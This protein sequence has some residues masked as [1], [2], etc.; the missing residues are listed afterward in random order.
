ME[1]Y[2]FLLELW[3]NFDKYTVINFDYLPKTLKRLVFVESEIN[4][5]D[6]IKDFYNLEEIL[7]V[8]KNFTKEKILKVKNVTI[9]YVDPFIYQQEFNMKMILMEI[10]RKMK[11]QKVFWIVF[12]LTKMI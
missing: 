1:N 7:I 9:K 2:V 12:N 11:M 5:F 8:N 6:F 10:L 3:L 4:N